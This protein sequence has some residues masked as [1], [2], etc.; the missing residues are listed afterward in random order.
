M[1]VVTGAS[2]FIGRA[3]VAALARRNSPV[4]AASRRALGFDHPVQTAIVTSYAQL[5]PPA[6]DSVLLHLAEPRNL[7]DAEN[8]G[9]AYIAERRVALEALLD[10]PWSHVI[11][12]SSAVVYGDTARVSHRSSDAIAPL[13]VYARAKAAC[14]ADVLSCGGT[15]ARIANVYGPGMAMNNIVSDVLKQ[16]STGGPLTVRNRKPVRD[17]LWI[18][19]LADG[20]ALLATRPKSGIFNFGTGRGISVGGLARTALDCVGQPERAIHASE[21]ERESYLVL[22]ISETVERLGW[23]PKVT[24]EQGLKRLLGPA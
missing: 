13:A 22:D 5:A 7:A 1:V 19:D 18:E 15:V 8:E 21:N 24:I 2:G 9:E 17:Y 16:A 12:A 23:Q 20:L 6:A 10:K 14:E 4:F 3:A 11:Y